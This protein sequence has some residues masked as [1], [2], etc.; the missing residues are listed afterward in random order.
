MGAELKRPRV[1]TPELGDI[2]VIRVAR[3]YHIGREATRPEPITAIA[4]KT[5]LVDAL[6]IAHRFVTGCQRVFLYD[7][8]DSEDHVEIKRPT[9]H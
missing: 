3:H 2:V 7:H 8:A 9:P 6:E 4:V 5:C 1:R